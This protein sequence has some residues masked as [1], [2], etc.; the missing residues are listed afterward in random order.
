MCSLIPRWY[1]W[2]V[3][4]L[5]A[6]FKRS[7]C[8]SAQATGTVGRCALGRKQLWWRAFP[9][10]PHWRTPQSGCISNTPVPLSTEKQR[11]KTTTRK[12]KKDSFWFG[13]CLSGT[14]AF[15][16]LAKKKICSQD[17]TGISVSVRFPCCPRQPNDDV[18]STRGKTQ[19]CNLASE[20]EDITFP[21]CLTLTR[22]LYNL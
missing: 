22:K 18:L 2:N 4:L 12:K 8:S 11:E 16:M 20:L 6:T 9:F 17:Q 14:W 5:Q 19:G 3:F 21:M 10:L 13:V 7:L 15:F 1:S